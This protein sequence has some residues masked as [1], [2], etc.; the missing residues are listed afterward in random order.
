MLTPPYRVQPVFSI[1]RDLPGF[2]GWIG[3]HSTLVPDVVGIVDH[4]KSIVC[5]QELGRRRNARIGVA[6]AAAL[7]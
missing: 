7:K 2:K 5:A 6:R 4:E 3:C 1:D